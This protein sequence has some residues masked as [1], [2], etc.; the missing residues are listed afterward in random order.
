[1]CGE[2]TQCQAGK[3]VVAQAEPDPDPEPDEKGKRKRKRKGRRGGKSEAGT[4]T[5]VD[6]SHIPAHDPNAI[7]TI[8]PESG[9][10]RLPDRTIRQ[11]LSRL[12]PKFNKC[13]ETAAMHSPE[14]LASGRIDFVFAIKPNGRINGVNVKAPKHLKVFGIVP[15]MRKVLWDHHFPSYDGPVTGVDY[16]FRV[17]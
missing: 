3:C 10:E 14:E 6:D 11:H 8:G 13:I 7:Q 2:G 1:M 9:T 16:S 15:C 17:E 5:P 4:F 12:E